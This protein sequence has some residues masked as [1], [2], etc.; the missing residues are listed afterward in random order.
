MIKYLR[1]TADLCLEYGK[2]PDDFGEWDQL[3][4]RRHKG[5]V[6]AYA[7]ASLAADSKSRSY[8]AAQLYWVGG[9]VCWLCQRQPLI[10]A[11]TA[12]AELV[13]L[14]EAHA[15][16]RS[17]QPTVQALLRD[18]LAQAE[19]VMYTDNSAALQL[20]TL[21][22]GSWRTRHLRLRGALIRQSI[23]ND[24]WKVSHLEG[25]FMK[26]DVGTKPVGP[27]RLLDLV[28]MMGMESDSLEM[29][30]TPPN[31]KIASIAVAQGCVVRIILAL[32]GLSQIQGATAVREHVVV[33]QPWSEIIAEGFL[34]GFGSYLGW[35]VATPKSIAVNL[36]LSV[37]QAS[38]VDSRTSRSPVSAGQVPQ[39]SGA[40]FRTS[41]S[42]VSAGQAPQAS[43]ADS[44]TGRSPVNAVQVPQASGVDSRTRR[45]PV[46]AVQVPQASGA[47]FRT[48]RSPVNAGQVPQASV[49][50][51]ARVA[52]LSM[53]FRRHRLLA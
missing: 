34:F 21:D 11:S 31:P 46:N 41:R 19:T 10:A 13:A 38:G 9:L 7:D 18:D 45:S 47:D 16:C 2:A 25:A 44:H 51:L 28:K 23:E 49:Q 6:E 8:G 30:S 52:A 43:G 53:Q 22:A 39:A 27:A 17:M 4:F 1:N 50:T 40:D 3:K 12:E 35:E 20:C 32:L 33:K 26:A 15:L 42:P 37:P 14:T 48:S 5:L 24:R 36:R 29:P